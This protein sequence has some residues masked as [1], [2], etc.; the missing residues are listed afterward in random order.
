MARM[1]ADV[2]QIITMQGGDCRERN[3]TTEKNRRSDPNRVEL[4]K[5]CSRCRTHK[6]HREVR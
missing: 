3:Y 4:R 2:R 6:T 5:Y 1:T